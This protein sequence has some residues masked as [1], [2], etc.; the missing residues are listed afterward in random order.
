MG[1]F[2]WVLETGIG[3]FYVRPDMDKIGWYALYLDN[4]H[5]GDFL[6]PQSAVQAVYERKTGWDPWDSFSRSQVCPDTG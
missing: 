2:M 6:T 1:C 5:L 4:F 3:T